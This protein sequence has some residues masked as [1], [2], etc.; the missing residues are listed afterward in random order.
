LVPLLQKRLA[1]GLTYAI[2][3]TYHMKPSLCIVSGLIS[4]HAEYARLFSVRQ[5]CLVDAF[6]GGSKLLVHCI[7]ENWSA[8]VISKV[9]GA[10]E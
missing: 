7:I 2:H 8:D 1:P 5:S 4:A 3:F 10:N 9:E 6:N